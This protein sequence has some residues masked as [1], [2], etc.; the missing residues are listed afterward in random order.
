MYCRTC[1]TKLHDNAEMC[2]KCGCRPL[3]GKSYCQSCGT[4][5][6][7]N[8]ELCVKCGEVL[9]LINPK[10]E[11]TLKL[12]QLCFKTIG[13]VLIAFGIFFFAMLIWNIAMVVIESNTYR[14]LSH[15]SAAGRCL[16]LGLLCFI[17]GKKIKKK[18]TS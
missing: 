7:E 13:Y 4:P 17:P 1:G 2:I 5:T 14:S 3:T 11:S 15:V 6:R 18:A 9:K 8:Q 10:N 16:V 12:K